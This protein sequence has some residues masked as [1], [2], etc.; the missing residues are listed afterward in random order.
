LALDLSA[1]KLVSRN[2]VVVLCT[3]IAQAAFLI[4]RF[5]I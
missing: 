4:V 1:L 2:N 5:Q 3:R